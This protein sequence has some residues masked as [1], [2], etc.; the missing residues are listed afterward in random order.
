MRACLEG[1][2]VTAKVDGVFVD[3]YCC[4]QGDRYLMEL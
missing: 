3:G 1:L 2:E 4:F